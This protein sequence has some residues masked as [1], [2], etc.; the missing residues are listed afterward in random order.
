MPDTIGFEIQLAEPVGSNPFFEAE[1]E[2][3]ISAS[4]ATSSSITE[5]QA[6]NWGWNV[7]SSRQGHIWRRRGNFF[8]KLGGNNLDQIRKNYKAFDYLK[9]GVA[10]QIK[11][12]DSTNRRTIEKA[13]T[14]AYKKMFAALKSDINLLG[15]HKAEL[16]II[17]PS[18]T[19]NSVIQIIEK[20]GKKFAGNQ[21]G[22]K[23]SPPKIIR[24]IP[25]SVGTVLRGMG[26]AGGALSIYQFSKDIEERDVSSAIGSGAGGAAVLLEIGGGLVGSTA[27]AASA[28]VVGAFALGY[29][30]GTVINNYF[31]AEDDHYLMSG[32][33]SVLADHGWGNLQEFYHEQISR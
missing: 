14:E 2:R 15:A 7:N 11:S 1:V 23:I 12:I 16:K 3:F 13:V 22:V 24:G 29:A 28:A 8:D 5:W 17:V 27:L 33:F 21:G 25:G 10:G 30:V 18:G 4:L 19:N 32:A 26:I 20:V 9:G 31:F 6:W